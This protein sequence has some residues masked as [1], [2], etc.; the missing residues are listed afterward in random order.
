MTESIHVL[1]DYR[2]RRLDHRNLII[3]RL[4]DLNHPKSKGEKWDIVGYFGSPGSL[5]HGLAKLAHDIDGSDGAD[6]LEQARLLTQAV[7][8]TTGFI[9]AA[10]E[11]A[12]FN[13]PPE[14]GTKK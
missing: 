10:L 9:I 4:R 5:A 6:L 11:A 7:E 2:I 14:D 3:E 8:R 12:L 13:E 1:K